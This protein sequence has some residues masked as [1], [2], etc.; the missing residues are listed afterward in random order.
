MQIGA[1]NWGCVWLCSPKDHNDE[2]LLRGE[3]GQRRVAVKL[4]FR[5]KKPTTAQRVRS[6]YVSVKLS[7][8][9][10]VETNFVADGT[11]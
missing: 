5:E 4:A 2:A 9:C 1:G 11:K 6:L 10:P 8:S 7:L 3:E